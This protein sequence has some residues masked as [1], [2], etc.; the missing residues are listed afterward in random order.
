MEVVRF[1]GE[2]TRTYASRVCNPYPAIVFLCEL[3][4]ALLCLCFSGFGRRVIASTG[5]VVVRMNEC[6]KCSLGASSKTHW[7]T[8]GNYY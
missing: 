1:Q 3:E 8:C 7:A 4:S 5:R 6:L 2:R